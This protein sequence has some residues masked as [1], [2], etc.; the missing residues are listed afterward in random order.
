MQDTSVITQPVPPLIKITKKKNHNVTTEPPELHYHN[1][2][3]NR[4]NF[5]NYNMMQF[6]AIKELSPQKAGNFNTKWASLKQITNNNK[7]I[8]E[9]YTSINEFQG[10]LT[11]SAW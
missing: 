1:Q 6:S 4:L 3:L 5:R 2:K 8:K 11:A 7:N 10:Q 9:L